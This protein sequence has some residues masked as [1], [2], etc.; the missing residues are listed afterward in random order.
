M[1]KKSVLRKRN[2]TKRTKQRVSKRKPIKHTTK[3]QRK[4][5]TRKRQMKVMKGGGGGETWKVLIPITHDH[6]NEE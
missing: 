3:K 5:T 1:V 4:H 2:S 6:K